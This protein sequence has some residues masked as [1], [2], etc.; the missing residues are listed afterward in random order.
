VRFKLIPG[1]IPVRRHELFIVMVHHVGTS[2]DNRFT[3]G[4]LPNDGALR[5]ASEIADV[6]VPLHERGIFHLFTLGSDRPY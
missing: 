4:S 6:L 5:I 3:D 2:L 1:I